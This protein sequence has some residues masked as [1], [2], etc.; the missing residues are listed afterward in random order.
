MADKMLDD[1]DIIDLT[2]LL[3][4]GDTSKKVKK[5]SGP[6]HRSQANEPDS[7]DLGKEISME[8]DVSVEEI[9]HEGERV[10]IDASLSEHE[11]IALTEESELCEAAV[12]DEGAAEGP[13]LDLDGAAEKILEEDVILSP[14]PDRAPRRKQKGTDAAGEDALEKDFDLSASEGTDNTLEEQILGPES[15]SVK[16]DLVAVDEVI[17]EDLPVS[18]AAERNADGDVVLEAEPFQEMTPS[19]IS[20]EN[21]EDLKQEIPGMVEAVVTP[22]ISELVKEIIAATREQLPGI[23]EKVIREEIEKLKKLD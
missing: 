5:E 22:L 11:E 15:E 3:E 1:D 6:A 23:V 10:D 18:S 14:E 13:E 8:Y 20:G 12:M 9:E 7:F 4:E 17:P 16:K 19:G 21:L 2:D